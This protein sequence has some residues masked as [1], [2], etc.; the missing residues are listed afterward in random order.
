MPQLHLTSS[1]VKQEDK[2][3]SDT[4]YKSQQ[5]QQIQTID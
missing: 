2:E 3:H 4:Q 5:L 1:N